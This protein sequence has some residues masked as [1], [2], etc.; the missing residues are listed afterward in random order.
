[1]YQITLIDFQG[2]IKWQEMHIFF[3]IMLIYR[4]LWQ[5]VAAQPLVIL[6]AQ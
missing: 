1:M 3:T 5:V 2:I 6:I 4:V